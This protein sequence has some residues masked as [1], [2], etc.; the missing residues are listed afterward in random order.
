M[1]LLTPPVSA[2]RLESVMKTEAVYKVCNTAIC[3]N[4]GT[5]SVGLAL[6]ALGLLSPRVGPANG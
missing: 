4:G 3:P 2:D 1:S 5:L 6:L